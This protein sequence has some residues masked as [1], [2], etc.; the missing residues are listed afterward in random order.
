MVGEFY[1]TLRNYEIIL[2]FGLDTATVPHSCS[3]ELQNRRINADF[4]RG[5]IIDAIKRHFGN[6]RSIVFSNL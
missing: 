6:V 1:I 3:S 4:L 5:F 2:N